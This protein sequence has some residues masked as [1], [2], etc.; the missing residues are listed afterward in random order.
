MEILEVE[1]SGGRPVRAT[2][3][4]AARDPVVLLCHGFKGF[5]DWGMFPWIAGRIAAAG[6]RVVRFDFSHNGVEARDFDRLDLFLLDTFTRHQEDLDA[7]AARFPDPLRLVGHSRGGAD[8]LLFA[9]RQPRVCA[10][11]TLAA[12][13][14]LTRAPAD[15]EAVLRERGYYPY[16][17]ARTGQLM[18]VARTQFDDARRYSLEVAARRYE[19]PLLLVHGLQDESVPPMDLRR[20]ASWHGAAETLEIDGAGHTFGAVHPFQGATPHLERAVEAVAAFL[21]QTR[22][23]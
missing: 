7:L 16:P 20:I 9:A 15:A 1:G 14:D 21:A 10:V 2:V 8:A 23:M 5:R 11:A 22:G 3:H 17:N 4:G 18:P 6:F 13:A 12:V 19:G